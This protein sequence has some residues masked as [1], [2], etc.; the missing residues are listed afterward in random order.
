[1]LKFLTGLTAVV[2]F[3]PSLMNLATNL[4]PYDDQTFLIYNKKYSNQ[5]LTIRYDKGAYM[6]ETTENS[7]KSDP[8]CWYMRPEPNK[9]GYHYIENCHYD[10]FRLA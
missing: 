4:K 6:L 10:G 3:E 2:V 1:M 8:E 7:R 5:R 9:P